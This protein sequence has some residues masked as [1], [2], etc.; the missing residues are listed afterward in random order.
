MRRFR[1]LFIVLA[2]VIALLAVTPYL[3]PLQAANIP[4]AE[5]ADPEGEF[6]EVDGV[7]LYVRQTGPVDGVPV[8]MLHGLLGTTEVWRY[9]RDALAAAGYRVIAYDRP[10]GGLSDKRWSLDYT[11]AAQAELAWGLLDTLNVN[12]AVLL[13]HSAGAKILTQ[14]VMQQ[15]DRVR[16]MVLVAP[17]IEEGGSPF[18]IG[19]LLNLPPVTRWMQVGLRVIFSEEGVRS[20]IRSVH[21][22]PSFLTE[23]DYAVYLRGFQTPNWDTGFLALT[24]DSGRRQA[25]VADLADVTI[26]ALIVHGDLDSVVPVETGR[27]VA[28]TLVNSTLIEYENVG[29]QPME[30]VAEQFNEDVIGWLDGIFD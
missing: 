11:Q 12:E 2:I 3:I 27:Q 26:P 19:P 24:R 30:E 16:S 21:A 15:P 7:S 28:A 29:H 14:M 8:L 10:G 20:V 5:L 18:G 22:D 13:S 1:T 25:K 4:P 23:D 9:N 6:V 17:A